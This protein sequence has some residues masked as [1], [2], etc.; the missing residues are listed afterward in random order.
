MKIKN[1]LEGVNELFIKNL[2][3]EASMF[4]YNL[5]SFCKEY[6]KKMSKEKK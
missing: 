4:F 1:T 2:V 3:H 6:E 5:H